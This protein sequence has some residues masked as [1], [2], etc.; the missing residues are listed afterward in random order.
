MF[1]RSSTVTWQ[2][3]AFIFLEAQTKPIS[4]S[5]CNLHGIICLVL[6]SRAKVMGP[7]QLTAGMSSL[8]TAYSLPSAPSTETQLSD[9]RAVF[10]LR[11]LKVEKPQ[12]KISLNPWINAWRTIKR[13]TEPGISTSICFSIHKTKIVYIPEF[14]GFICSIA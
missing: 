10:K 4:Q 11:C 9:I 6:Y 14:Q 2:R 1:F 7:T 3:L 5:P 12:H 8:H 13:A